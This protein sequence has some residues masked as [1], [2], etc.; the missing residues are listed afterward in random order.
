MELP[1][2]MRHFKLIGI[3]RDFNARNVFPSFEAV[4]EKL[5]EYMALKDFDITKHI[6]KRTFERDKGEIERLYGIRITYNRGGN[7]GY[8]IDEADMD[9]SIFN[10]MIESFEVFSS[11]EMSSGFPDF[12]LSEKRRSA[13]GGHF[14]F[15]VKMIQARQFI[16][17]DYQKYDRNVTQHYRVA[18]IALKE[19]ERRWYLIA[20][21]AESNDIRAFGLDRIGSAVADDGRYKKDAYSLAAIKKG[22]EDCFA[23]FVSDDP[24]EAI[25]LELDSTDA[26]YVASFPIHHSQKI[27]VAEDATKVSLRLKITE[28]FIQELLSRAWSVKVLKPDSLRERLHTIFKIAMERNQ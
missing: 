19:S 10:N 16:A 13:I 12:I 24:V 17:F 15:L 18:P 20:A 3:I 6:S 11:L 2:H 26:H 9:L 5:K 4:L 23:M 14:Y 25:E 28:D 7:T 8:E 27:E 21:L 22:Y 1:V